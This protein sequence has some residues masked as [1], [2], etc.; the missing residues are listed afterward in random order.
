MFLALSI[1][2]AY[3]KKRKRQTM[4]SVFGVVLGV[5]F[6]IGMSSMMKGMQNNLINTIVDVSPHVLISEDFREPQIQP[7][8]KKYKS[9]TVEIRSLKPKENI[10]GI[11]HADLIMKNLRNEGYYVAGTISTQAILNYNNNKKGVNII[12]AEAIYEEKM[13]NIEKNMTE[14][15]FF[16]IDSD[17]NGIVLG[18]GLSRELGV[19]YGNRVNVIVANG[20][21]NRMKVVGIFNTGVRSFDNRMVFANLRKVQTL[22]NK[23]NRITEI[24]IKLKDFNKA[25]EIAAKIE[26]R[27]KYKTQSWQEMMSNIFVV[28]KIQNTIMYS[29]VGAILLVA[30]FGIYNII[31]TSAKEKEGDIAILRSMGFSHIDIKRIFLLQGII[32]GIIGMIIGCLIGFLIVQYMSSIRFE[33]KESRISGFTRLE[34]LNL[35]KSIWQYIFGSLFAVTASILASYLPARKASKLDPIQIIRRGT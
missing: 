35:Y 29:S 30:C 11:R 12:G 9:K 14:G 10:K 2:S 27:Y 23:P 4:L 24:G 8:Q 18:Q 17:K 15:S 34:R 5:A 16:N 25:P 22:D 1:A 6:F 3:L 28:F 26:A 32:V 33:I 7:L 31:S 13:L 20:S 21:I 19:S